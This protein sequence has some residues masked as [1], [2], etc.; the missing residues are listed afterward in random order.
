MSSVGD[1]DSSVKVEEGSQWRQGSQSFIGSGLLRPLLEFV[2]VVELFARK[3]WRH[4]AWRSGFWVAIEVRQPDR[5]GSW[6]SKQRWR[7]RRRPGGWPSLEAWRQREAWHRRRQLLT[8]EEGAAS[9]LTRTNL[10]SFIFK[11]I[12][13]FYISNWGLFEARRIGRF[14]VSF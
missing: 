4:K 12:L 8:G 3:G 2:A 1:E 5:G 13:F 7:P 10:M 14:K 6:R 9:S 11:Q